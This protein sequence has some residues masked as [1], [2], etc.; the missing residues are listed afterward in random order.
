MRFE[1]ER[2][3]L[4][5]ALDFVRLVAPGKTPIEMYKTCYLS[6]RN[7]RLTVRGTDSTIEASTSIEAEVLEG[8][9]VC[10]D[11]RRFA[12]TVRAANLGQ[13][14]FKL[15]RNQLLLQ[16]GRAAIKINTFRAEDFP[17]PKEPSLAPMFTAPLGALK[18]SIDEVK[19][20]AAR[21]ESRPVFGGALL[22]TQQ[23]SVSFSATD[24]HRLAQSVIVGSTITE[25]EHHPAVIPTKAL[26]LL[27]NKA[28][29]GDHVEVAQQGKEWLAFSTGDQRVMVK[30][31]PGRFP[32]FSQ[33]I[34][35]THSASVK[36]DRDRLLASLK[37]AAIYRDD[38]NDNVQLLLS[39]DGLELN[40]RSLTSGEIK[41]VV[42]CEA[43]GQGEVRLQT[44]YLSQAVSACRAGDVY[45][46]VID[47]ESPVKIHD[48]RDGVV[49]IVM[50]I[51]Q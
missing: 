5:G 6:A 1:V 24:G 2:E 50:P 8:G 9:E 32:D 48:G 23:D 11:S 34:P 16:T 44:Y 41:E 26:S 7:G 36:I 14:K 15:A 12:S 46:E 43:V 31:I 3:H 39:D 49:F 30:P 47:G 37:R 17:E 22:F 29:I 38:T 10:V 21:D 13:L 4:L 18:I 20:C 51:N 35:T 40:A 28:F 33:V 45:I 27:S 42:P 25:S 19:F